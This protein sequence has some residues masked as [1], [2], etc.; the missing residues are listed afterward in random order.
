MIEVRLEETKAKAWAN[1]IRRILGTGHLLKEQADERPSHAS[2]RPSRGTRRL[3]PSTN[4]AAG[5]FVRW[6]PSS[7]SYSPGIELGR[8]DPRRQASI[9]TDRVEDA[10]AVAP[11]RR[12]AH[13]S[14][15]HQGRT[16]WAIWAVSTSG[17]TENENES[18]ATRACWKR[19]KGS[20]AESEQRNNQRAT[21]GICEQRRQ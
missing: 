21:R 19:R 1:D 14:I 10:T 17:G 16:L 11:R 6:R 7:L 15:G 2:D 3:N 9:A 20:F 8:A 12:A 18:D 13:A 4:V 5:E